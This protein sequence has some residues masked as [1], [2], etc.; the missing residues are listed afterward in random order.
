MDLTN[1]TEELIATLHVIA[2][3]E[4]SENSQK[5]SV[6]QVFTRLVKESSEAVRGDL[7]KMSIRYFARSRPRV[8]VR[9]VAKK[10]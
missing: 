7:K 10:L 3:G 5:G 1:K 2:A 6:Q 4:G 8:S 9:L